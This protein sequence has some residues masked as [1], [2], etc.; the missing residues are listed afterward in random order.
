MPALRDHVLQ[1]SLA[2][3]AS[4]PLLKLWLLRVH[5][6]DVQLGSFEIVF[7]AIGAA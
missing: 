1:V 6:L 4:L 3:G 5:G 7:D 2:S